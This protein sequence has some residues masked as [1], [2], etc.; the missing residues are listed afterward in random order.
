[1]PLVQCD[2]F[3]TAAYQVTDK[4]CIDWSQRDCFLAI[5]VTKGQGSFVIDGETVTVETGDTLLL[6]ATTSKVEA[7]GSLTFVTVT[8]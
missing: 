6:P 1:M 2:Y 3:Q 5:I 7:S 8:L 4:V